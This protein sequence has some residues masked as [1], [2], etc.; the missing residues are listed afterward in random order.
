MLG[1]L[2][3]GGSPFSPPGPVAGEHCRA[4]VPHLGSGSA[5]AGFPCGGSCWVSLFVEMQHT[6]VR[7]TWMPA[8]LTPCRPGL[9]GWGQRSP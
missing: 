9:P 4:A 6:Q 2:A 5:G 3:P 7:H 8:S 1:V